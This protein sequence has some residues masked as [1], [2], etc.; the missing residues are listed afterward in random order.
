VEIVNLILLLGP[1][2]GAA[3]GYFADGAVG[4]MSGIAIPIGPLILAWLFGDG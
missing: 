1:V 4:A 3:A 2:L